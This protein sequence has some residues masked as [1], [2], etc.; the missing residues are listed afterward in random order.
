MTRT[1]GV[2]L[3]AAAPL[4][5]CDGQV[6]THYRD[7]ESEMRLLFEVDRPCPDDPIHRVTDSTQ[8]VNLALSGPQNPFLFF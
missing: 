7:A 5:A 2:A 3:L 8:A 1:L 4:L 6:D